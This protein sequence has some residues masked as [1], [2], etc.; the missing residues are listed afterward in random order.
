MTIYTL[1]IKT[2]K[3]T[4]LKYLGQ[5]KKDPFKYLGSGKDWVHHLNENGI[6][7]HTDILMKCQSKKELNVWGR[8]YSTYYNI[9]NAMD[10]YGNRIWANIIPET[11][12]GGYTGNTGAKNPAYGKIP[13]NKGLTKDSDARV[14]KY[15]E[16]VSKATKG[17]RPAHNKGK[18]SATKGIKLNP[19]PHQRGM[20]N[21]AN[22]PEVRAKISAALQGINKGKKMPARTAEHSAKIAAGLQKYWDRKKAGIAPASTIK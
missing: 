5:T 6:E 12:G 18:P 13:W 10:D 11:G 7:H 9:L 22:R 8:Y 2:H 19:R 16:S 20:N 17:I 3:I 15:A 21:P 1:Y 14:A 4:G